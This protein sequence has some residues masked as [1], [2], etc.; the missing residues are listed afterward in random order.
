MLITVET[1]H[2]NQWKWSTV[3]QHTYVTEAFV[4]M[5]S[6]NSYFE[7]CPGCEFCTSQKDITECLTFSMFTWAHGFTRDSPFQEAGVDLFY[8]RLAFFNLSSLQG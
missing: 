6:S 8:K 2:Y 5:K 1:R 3:G 4:Q 7:L